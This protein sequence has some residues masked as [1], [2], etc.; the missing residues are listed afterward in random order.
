MLFIHS[1]L[2]FTLYLGGTTLGNEE[3]GRLTI[4]ATDYLAHPSYNSNNLNND[5]ALIRLPEPIEF[6]GSYNIHVFSYFV[7]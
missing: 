2:S 5:V 1:A 3:D 7:F 4:V 6:S